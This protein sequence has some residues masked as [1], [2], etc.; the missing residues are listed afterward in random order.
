MGRET[1]IV[2]DISSYDVLMARESLE[3]RL[4][5]EAFNKEDGAELNDLWLPVLEI[6]KKG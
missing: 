6:L 4:Q 1:Q 3:T 2:A 5:A